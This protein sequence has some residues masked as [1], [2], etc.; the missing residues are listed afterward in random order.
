MGEGGRKEE[1]SLASGWEG[2]GGVQATAVPVS[3]GVPYKWLP[4]NPLSFA[5]NISI[6]LSF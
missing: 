3:V 2:G 4:Y 5:E 6:S 1:G